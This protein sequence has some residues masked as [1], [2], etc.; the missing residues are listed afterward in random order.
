VNVLIPGISNN[1]NPHHSQDLTVNE[2]SR[3]WRRQENCR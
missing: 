2:D 3:L 1:Q